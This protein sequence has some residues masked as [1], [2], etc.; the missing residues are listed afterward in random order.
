MKT[1]KSFIIEEKKLVKSLGF[2]EIY[3]NKSHTIISHGGNMGN[4]IQHSVKPN[5][6]RMLGKG[7]F[8]ELRKHGK[9]S[10]SPDY[11]YS[12]KI[13][14]KH[15]DKVTN[16]SLKEDIEHIDESS[17]QGLA[18]A[19]A[20]A[21]EISK[22]EGVVQHI[23][24][25]P[26]TGQHTVSDWYDSDRTVATYN[27][28]KLS[29]AV[30]Q[31]DEE[32]DYRF[33]ISSG[34]RNLED[35][36]NNKK[37]SVW[38]YKKLPSGR[39]SGVASGGDVMKGHE[40]IDK[41]HKREYPDGSFAIHHEPSF[42]ASKSKF[43]AF[44]R[45]M[46]GESVEQ[47]EEVDHIAEGS[48]AS[49]YKVKSIGTDKNGDYYISPNTGKKVYKKVKVGAH[50]TPSGEIKNE[51]VEQIDELKKSTVKSWLSKQDVIPP[52]KPGMDRKAFNKRIKTRSASWDRALDR[53][54]G[55]KP[56]SEDAYQDS[57]AAT[58]TCFDGANA[59]DNTEP[60]Q[61]GLNRKREMSKSARIIKSIYNKLGMVKEEL[62]DHEK[63]DKSVATY[64]KKPKMSKTDVKQDLGDTE[65]KAAAIM[66]GGTTMTGEKRDTIEIDPM[67]QRRPAPGQ[68]M[69]K[70]V[71]R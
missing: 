69:S 2:T 35:L 7:K 68:P 16:N 34:I 59:P 31:I 67:M 50:E 51:E 54:T 44:N 53:M 56:T 32:R 28:G 33:H 70:K 37:I 43:K 47:I 61:P 14:N 3:R 23:E 20:K 27:N 4:T 63:E 22:R 45:A 40:F 19:H 64:G 29:E 6:E 18:A 48:S 52:K 8:D 12:L 65:P 41:I 71:N 24:K 11:S 21:K 30:G 39:H 49:K 1:F 55:H 38:H 36:K 26:E 13:P 42:A 17:D 66:S 25:D 5:V 57:Q 9:E 46:K 58:Q 60:Q 62:Y 15:F 10:G